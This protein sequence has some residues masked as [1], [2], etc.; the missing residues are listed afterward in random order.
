[1]RNRIFLL[2]ALST[3]LV[4]AYVALNRA[5]SGSSPVASNGIGEQEASAKS[6]TPANPRTPHQTTP[7]P[8]G[9]T[10]KNVAR[11]EELRGRLNRARET[12]I[13]GDGETAREARLADSD[14]NPNASPVVPRPLGSLDKEYIQKQIKEIVPLVAECYELALHSNPDLQGRVVVEIKLIGEEDIGGL[15]ESSRVV[16]EDSDVTEPS[17]LECV[18]E[19]MYAVELDAPEGGGSVVIKYPLNFASSP[20]ESEGDH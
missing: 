12:R 7:A 6:A 2:L 11:Y 15:I 5:D 10:D 19:T 16:E 20:P 3:L 9:A 13:A 14:E 18:R 17:F 1:M 8:P 4:G